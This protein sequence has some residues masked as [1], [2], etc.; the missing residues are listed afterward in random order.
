M[1]NYPILLLSGCLFLSCSINSKKDTDSFLYKDGNL[2]LTT[3]SVDSIKGIELKTFVADTGANVTEE[4][5]RTSFLVRMDKTVLENIQHTSFD[6]LLCDI[7]CKGPQ[8]KEYS[9]LNT[10][11]STLTGLILYPD[12]HIVFSHE[13]TRAL[14]IDIPFRKLELAP[15]LHKLTI[16][17]VVYPVKFTNDTNRAEAK[18]IEHIG[19]NPLYTKSYT[20]SVYTPVLKHNTITIK[21]VI[22]STKNKSASSYDFALGGTGLPDPYWQIWCGN[23]LIYFSSPVKNSLKITQSQTSSTFYTAPKDIITIAFLDY[24]NGPFNSDDV[25]EKFSGTC[26]QLKKTK[27]FKSSAIAT[28]TIDLK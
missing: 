20:A 24:D 28:A 19:S 18:H 9:Y 4:G 22:I 16:S 21:D 17:F 14:D 3:H 5:I 25:I 11:L 1:S 15:G 27:K 2:L 12:K 7:T 10:Y 23:E 26:A 13:A 6:A 8:G